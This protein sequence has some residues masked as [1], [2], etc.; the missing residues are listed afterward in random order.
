MYQYPPVLLAW[1]WL[2]LSTTHASS[3]PIPTPVNQPFNNPSR[4]NDFVHPST[5]AEVFKRAT[6]RS[7][8]QHNFQVDTSHTSQYNYH[9]IGTLGQ[10]PP[11]FWT[12]V[13]TFAPNPP[14]PPP[15]PPP[16]KPPSKPK[17]RKLLP[18]PPASDDAPSTST[19]RKASISGSQPASNAKQKGSNP[20]EP[21]D[22]RS[23]PDYQPAS[24]ESALL[25][26]YF[27]Y[28]DYFQGL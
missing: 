20:P 14:S 5:F 25:D 2:I 28:D 12:F 8:G 7:G 26:K 10:S 27:N 24:A 6:T 16:S 9:P 4:L 3:S 23:H 19:T 11:H 21:V 13:N 22:F 18:K 15:S 17:L 1:T